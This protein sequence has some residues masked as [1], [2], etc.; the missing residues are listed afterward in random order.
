MSAAVTVCHCTVER[1]Q[2]FGT[3]P[4]IN[5]LGILAQEGPAC[6]EMLWFAT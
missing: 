3:I 6:G 1:G 2:P 4:G 5:R